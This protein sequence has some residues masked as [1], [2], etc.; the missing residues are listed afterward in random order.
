[1]EVYFREGQE[2][3]KKSGEETTLH[4]YI[5]KK[6][7]DII[8]LTTLEQLCYASDFLCIKDGRILAIEVEREIKNVLETLTSKAQ[9][10]PYRY[11]KLL[12]QARK[13]YQDLRVLRRILPAQERILPRRH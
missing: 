11:G 10:D 8:N 13:D 4:D 3:Y 1:M 12:E 2:A 6:G 7:F 9:V 5:K